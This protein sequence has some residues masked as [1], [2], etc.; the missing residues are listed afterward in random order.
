MTAVLVGVLAL[1]LFL[2]Y[3]TLTRSAEG[4]SRDRL[5]RA[6]RQVAGTV[7]AAVQDRL[8][9]L[10]AV[11]RDSA[12]RDALRGS[13]VDT[14]RVAQALEQLR[15][16]ADS[17]A[18]LPVEVW[19]AS[20]RRI[21]YVG[22]DVA[23]G[24]P[25][26]DEA[27]FA[28]LYASGGRVYFWILAPIEEGGRRLG[29]IVQQ[30]RV[31]GPHEANRTLRDLIGEEVALYMRNAAS[32]VW[33]A[34]PGDPGVGPSHRDTTT[35]GTYSV[36]PG[37]GR[38]IFGEAAVP[39]TPWVS[40]LETPVSSVH[41]RVRGTLLTLA[42]LSL[43][44][45]AGGAALSWLI[46][47]RVTRPLVSLTHAAEA[48]A[49]GDDA[50]HVEDGGSDEI[51]RLAASFNQMASEVATSRRELEQRIADAEQARAEAERASRA[52]SD[53]LAVMSHEL[54][55][56]LN[57][58]G[59]YA[60]LLELG[61]HG[62]IN[63]AQRDAL[64]R[65]GRSQAHLLRLITDVLNF[66]KLDAGQVEYAVSDVRVEDVLASIEPLV[67]LQVQAKRLTFTW[68]TCDVPG[69][70]ARADPDKLQQIL[71]NVLTNAIKFTPAGGTIAVVCDATD[72][73]VYI[74]IRDTGVGIPT[75]RLS[76]VFE[77]FVQGD[78]KLSSPHEGV[79]LGLAIG[80]DL[81]RGMGGDLTA[82]SEVGKGSVF[83]LGLPRAR[84]G[85]EREARN[86]AEAASGSSAASM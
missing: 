40:V 23:D 33:S 85:A 45:I 56:P 61:V 65:L 66:A 1:S 78:R 37:I 34:S 29:Y 67:T 36:R 86:D 50:R 31:I 84:T 41:A 68:E 20:G 47:R 24:R 49:R 39:G 3:S 51:G 26:L 71:L 11:G 32:D 44:L 63:E 8:E 81:A 6:S 2:T 14:A 38:T 70:T 27:P 77:P 54:R 17:A 28:P 9:R 48:I 73:R 82:E 30:R 5:T 53:F 21:A 74:H 60:Q 46:S 75:N 57:A 83:T 16:A 15:N 58:I 35:A 42:L 4:A 62:P 12:V 79:G 43:L 80:R 69:L 25:P 59:G 64:A 72:E 18:Q 7:Q 10:R 76:S 13:G 22:G 55:T 52:K 19:D